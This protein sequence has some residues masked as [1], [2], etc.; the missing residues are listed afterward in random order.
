MRIAALLLLLSTVAQAGEPDAGASVSVSVTDG[1]DTTIEVKRG[2]LKV[3]AG[4]EHTHLSAG[5]GMEVKKGGKPRKVSLLAVPERR[6][7]SDGAHVVET[8]VTL[9]WAAVRNAQKYHVVVADNAALERPQQESTVGQ[10]GL[11]LKLT[12]GTWYW[13][14]VALDREGLQGKPSPVQKLIVDAAPPKL[15]SGKPKWK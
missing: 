8:E 7:P 13:R 3:H 9:G 12:P 4:G 11:P 14:V 1:G 10:S 15:K 2:D 5:Q 6:V